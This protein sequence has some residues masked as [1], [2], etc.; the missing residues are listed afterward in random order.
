MV[1]SHGRNGTGISCA[2]P[3]C[4]V[5]ARKLCGDRLGKLPPHRK[6]LPAQVKRFNTGQHMRKVIDSNIL[7]AEA[8]RIYLAQSQHNYAVLTDWAAMEAYKG[9]TLQSIYRSM[10][11]LATRPKQVV[12]LKGTQAICGL[13]GRRA[14]LQRRMI[15]DIQTMGFAEYCRNLQVARNGDRR[16]ERRLLVHER[17]ANS[18]M[19]RLLTDA[20]LIPDVIE[21]IANTYSKAEL[22]LLRARRPLTDEMLSKTSRNIREVVTTVFRD[23]PKVQKLPHRHEFAN[24]YLFRFAICAYVWA[25]RLIFA[26]GAAHTKAENLRNDMVDICFVVYGTFFD[27]LLTADGGAIELYD[28][29]KWW[30]DTLCEH[31]RRHS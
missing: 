25:L 17:E 12:I 28:D 3:G 5:D 7:Q 13:R 20:R 19:D 9:H 26:G 2:C 23:H 21:A 18:Q 31:T 1:V 10:E 14:G 24:T 27:G 30:L 29:M 16:I 11:I 4:H 15:D 6:H 8:L 22:Q